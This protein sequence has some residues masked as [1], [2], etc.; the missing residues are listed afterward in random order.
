MQHR[1]HPQ[2]HPDMNQVASAQPQ[3]DEI[4]VSA[5]DLIEMIRSGNG[6][7]VNALV[8]QMLDERQAA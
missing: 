1:P 8:R 5:T 7:D 6:T 3:T 2:L 4:A